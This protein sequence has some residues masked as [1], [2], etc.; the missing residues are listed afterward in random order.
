MTRMFAPKAIVDYE[1]TAYVEPIANVRI[2]LDRN[3]SVSADTAHFQ[4]GEYRKFPLL[5]EGQHVLEA[6][7][8]Y[9]LPQY[10]K[11]LIPDCSGLVQTAFSKYYMGRVRL[12]SLV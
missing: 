3:I 2:T 1:R 12:Q 8:D 7:F 9:V 10:L 11:K 6:K 5:P 4:D